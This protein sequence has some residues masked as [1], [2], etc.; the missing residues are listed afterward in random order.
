MSLGTH[1]DPGPTTLRTAVVW[2][3]QP[4]NVLGHLDL[5]GLFVAKRDH[6]VHHSGPAGRNIARRE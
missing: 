6:R 4:E 5:F 1:L 2:S 3:M